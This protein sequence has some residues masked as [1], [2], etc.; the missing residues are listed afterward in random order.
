MRA[1]DLFTEILDGQ[2]LLFPMVA[3]IQTYDGATKT[4]TMLPH[5]KVGG[6]A[7]SP[8]ED[9]K[10]LFP[11]SGGGWTIDAGYQSGDVVLALFCCTNVSLWLTGANADTEIEQPQL[12]NAIIVG[13]LRRG[14]GITANGVTIQNDAGTVKLEMTETGIAV[15]LTSPGQTFNLSSLSPS[16]IFNLL[17]H[18]HPV[19]GDVTGAPTPGS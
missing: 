17:T 12:H 2:M 6:V 15:T 19:T 7:P 11:H 14:A 9:V 16:G 3:T 4:A 10:C 1:E 13:A 18:T 5:L 8:V